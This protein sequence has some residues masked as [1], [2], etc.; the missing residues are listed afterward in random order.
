MEGRIEQEEA[1]YTQRQ[2]GRCSGVAGVWARANTVSKHSEH[3]RQT[4]DKCSKRGGGAYAAQHRVRSRLVQLL[5]SGGGEVVERHR[6]RTPQIIATHSAQHPP[7]HHTTRTSALQQAADRHHVRAHVYR[8]SMRVTR[9]TAPTRRN[10]NTSVYIA[11]FRSVT[12]P[13][14]AAPHHNAPYAVSNGRVKREARA[15]GE[16]RAR[17]YHRSWAGVGADRTSAPHSHG[18]GGARRRTRD[19]R[20]SQTPPRPHSADSSRCA[21]HH[22]QSHTRRRRAGRERVTYTSSLY[23]L[24]LT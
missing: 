1:A 3:A 2:K 5:E 14:R 17:T 15:T 23:D 11:V 16:E 13:H 7:P 18:R 12:A 8:E 6:Q 24:V 9:C 20:T 21:Q 10:T 22:K 19:A 4:E